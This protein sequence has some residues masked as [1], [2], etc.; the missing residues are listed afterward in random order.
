MFRH[1]RKL[2]GLRSREEILIEVVRKGAH[3]IDVR[4]PAEYKMGHIQQAVNISLDQIKANAEKI[5]KIGKPVITCCQTGSRSG[6]ASNI[7]RRKGIE[8]YNGGGWVN[9]KDLIRAATA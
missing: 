4:T 3:I 1:I 8:A 9:L 6:R 5:G 2:F 7:L